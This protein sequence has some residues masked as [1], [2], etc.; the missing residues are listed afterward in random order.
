MVHNK[1]VET[2]LAGGLSTCCAKTTTAPL[3]R[4]KI[5]FQA[6]NQHYKNM[7]VFGALKAIYKKEGT[8]GYYRGNGAMM[9]RVF[10][11]GAIQFMSYEQFKTIF[12]DVFDHGHIGKMIA[13]GLAGITACAFTYPLDVVRSRLAFQV[14]DEHRY[15]GICSTLK[16]ICST[17]GGICALYRGFTPTGLSM[18]PA[19]GLGFYAFESFKDFFVSLNGAMT[20]VHPVSGDTVLTATGGLVCGALSGATSQTVAYPLDVV[21]RRMQLAGS[22][23]DGHK[24]RNCISTF[25]T[26]Y[27]EDGVRHGLYRGLSIN[28][29]RV[30]PQI[31]VM[32]A[33]YEMTKQFL[34]DHDR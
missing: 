25:I 1:L 31:A 32:F 14:A 2:S 20:R 26:V 7:S 18:I 27:T 3:E 33:V 24:Y 34:H 29:L 4:L 21:R 19:V 5:L 30:C 6:Q 22:L 12:C 16:Q 15:C 13:G 11:Y 28:Y 10:P 9:V 8:L 17:E 23:A